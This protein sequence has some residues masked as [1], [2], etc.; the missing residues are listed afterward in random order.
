MT[1]K[2]ISS[3]LF[4]HS[5]KHKNHSLIQIPI[6]DIR[7]QNVLQHKC[8]YTA[9][10]ESLYF[11]TIQSRTLIKLT[12]ELMFH[13][14]ILK[15]RNIDD[16]HFNMCTYSPLVSILSYFASTFLWLIFN[17]STAIYFS[18][19]F[20]LLL[21][22]GFVKLI[23][24]LFHSTFHMIILSICIEKAILNW[25]W[26]SWMWYMNSFSISYVVK[27]KMSGMTYFEAQMWL[28]KICFSQVLDHQQ[29]HKKIVNIQNV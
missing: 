12:I 17:I 4:S 14:Y 26:I 9:L 25:T 6:V 27:M 24:K 8:L 22:C 2:S 21:C 10:K 20:L 18:K 16:S 5:M 28:I 15:R 11:K 23:H 3:R 7:N 13:I 1:W 29:S 19:K